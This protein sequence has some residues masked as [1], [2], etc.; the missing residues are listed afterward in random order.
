MSLRGRSPAVNLYSLRPD[1]LRDLV[2]MAAEYTA[3]YSAPLVVNEGFRTRAQQAALYATDPKRAAAPGKS[4]HEYGYAFD[5][6]TV[7]ADRLESSGLLKRYGFH[8]P[9]KHETWHIERVGLVYDAVRRAAGV[10]ALVV[11]ALF[12]WF[13]LRK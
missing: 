11:M 9:L 7:L 4:M 6:D 1:V 10:A 3:R 8:R 12:G 5:I 13:V 2:S